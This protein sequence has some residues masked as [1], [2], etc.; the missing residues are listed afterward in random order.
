MVDEVQEF[1]EKRITSFLNVVV[2]TVQWVSEIQSPPEPPRTKKAPWLFGAARV[3][4]SMVNDVGYLRAKI[5]L[6][7]RRHGYFNRNVRYRYNAHM[8]QIFRYFGMPTANFR[9]SRGVNRFNISA[10]AYVGI[11]AM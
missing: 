10:Y 5:T 4:K 11:S 6:T 3:R 9:S 8:R 7:E 1:V 2:G